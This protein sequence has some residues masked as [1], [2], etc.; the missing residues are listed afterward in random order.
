MNKKAFFVSLLLAGLV[1]ISIATLEAKESQRDQY[2]DNVIS[3][4]RL[5]ADSIRQLATS[6]FKYSPNLVRHTT[7]LRR[8]FGMLGPMDLHAAKAATM[9][10]DDIV[11][12]PDMFNKLAEHCQ[13]AIKDL[14]QVAVSRV[15]GGD[16]EPVLKALGEVQSGCDGCHALLDGAAPDV[17]G[18]GENGN[19]D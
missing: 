8:T 1:T 16:A 14:Y 12:S 3:I 18:H 11:I 10:K 5:H 6:D 4:L 2:V 13:K 7:A 17:W 15:E 19:K 9:Q